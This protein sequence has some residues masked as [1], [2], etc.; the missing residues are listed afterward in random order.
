MNF[1]VSIVLYIH[2]ILPVL[3]YDMHNS[4]LNQPE[5]E[6]EATEDDYKVGNESPDKSDDDY[7]SDYAAD[8]GEYYDYRAE[9]EDRK[10]TTKTTTPTTKTTTEAT[11]FIS[12]NLVNLPI[13]IFLLGSDNSTQTYAGDYEDV[14]DHI[15]TTKMK[16]RRLTYALKHLTLLD[17]SEV[18]CLYFLVR[19]CGGFQEEDL[20][21]LDIQVLY[22][23][24][25]VFKKDL[26]RLMLYMS[27]QMG[28]FS[29]L[30]RILSGLVMETHS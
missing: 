18:N 20:L 11:G 26:G 6:S 4:V 15:R 27:A 8:E 13:Y 28:I 2:F 7:Q 16:G 24:C 10:R 25:L 9:D 29:S 17:I 21:D 30:H 12:R 19:R 23:K 5:E 22:H 1:I 14:D 3:Y